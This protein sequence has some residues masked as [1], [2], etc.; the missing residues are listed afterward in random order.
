MK[1]YTYMVGGLFHDNLSPEV[2]ERKLNECSTLGWDLFTVVVKKVKGEDCTVY[3]FRRAGGGDGQENPRF[4]WSISDDT[5]RPKSQLDGS[6]KSASIARWK[7]SA[8]STKHAGILALPRLLSL[9]V[10]VPLQSL[11]Q[12][13]CGIWRNP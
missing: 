7:P 10:H 2:E 3:Y 9:W 13:W 12:N 8:L 6:F 1:A 5:P 11:W 4:D